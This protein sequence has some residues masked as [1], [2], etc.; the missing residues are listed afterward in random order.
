MRGLE[1]ARV[2]TARGRGR[3]VGTFQLQTKKPWAVDV[4]Y[5]TPVK[6][7]IYLVSIAVAPDMQR[8]GIGRTLVEFA[9]DHATR[10]PADVLRLDPTMPPPELAPST[11]S[12]A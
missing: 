7:P 6:K 2:F 4:A 9:A 3:I 11:A 8:Q 10:W 12:A 1:T 5:F